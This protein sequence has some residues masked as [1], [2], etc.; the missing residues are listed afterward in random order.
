MYVCIV[1]YMVKWQQLVSNCG[2]HTDFWYDGRSH[3]HF[4]TKALIITN[5]GDLVSSGYSPNKIWVFMLGDRCIK[6][7]K[8]CS[9]F[10]ISTTSSKNLE[11]WAPSGFKFYIW[12]CLK[13]VYFFLSPPSPRRQA[14]NF[15]LYMKWFRRSGPGPAFGQSYLSS[16]FWYRFNCIHMYV[17]MYTVSVSSSNIGP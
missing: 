13:K 15:L 4:L 1:P 5:L 3:T 12:T 7:P 16:L 14:T 2:V 17:H 10:E 6:L 11:V 8:Y 9:I